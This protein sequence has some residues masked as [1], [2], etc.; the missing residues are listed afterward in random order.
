MNSDRSREKSRQPRSD[1]LSSAAGS[2]VGRSNNDSRSPTMADPTIICPNCQ[3]DIK[4]TESLAAP[5]IADSRKRFDEQ[6]AQKEA[7]IAARERAIRDQQAQIAAAKTAIDAEVAAKLDKERGRIAAEE[8]NKAQRLVATE[9]GPEGP[10]AGGPERGFEAAGRQ[11][12][13]GPESRGR[14]DPQAAGTDDAKREIDLTIQRQVQAELAQAREAAKKDAEDGLL[15]KVREREEQI[16]AMARQI[17]DLKRRA[18]QGSQQLQ[19]ET[20]ELQL[21]AMLRLG[22]RVT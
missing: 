10:G 4:L 6:L 20:H 12:R 22:F 11:A 9:S 5:L 18:E 15:L 14:P 8:A 16:A 3:T 21:E 19:G 17:E 7:E 1:S 2:I 13:R